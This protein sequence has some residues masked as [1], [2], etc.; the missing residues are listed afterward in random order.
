MPTARRTS[1]WRTGSRKAWRCFWGPVTGGSAPARTFMVG[2]IDLDVET[3]AGSVAVADVDGD[4]RLDLLAGTC[5]GEKCASSLFVLAGKGDGSFDTATPYDAVG[6]G[7]GLVVTADVNGDAAP[8]AV[9]ASCADWRCSSGS[10]AILLRDTASGTGAGAQSDTSRDLRTLASASAITTGTP[11]AAAFNLQVVSDASPDL[12]ICS[13][14]STAPRRAGRRAAEKVWALFYWSHILKRQT[15][16]IVLHGFEV[17][18]PIRNF[19]DYGFTMCSTITG[20][21]P[22]AVREPSASSTSTGTSAIT[23][24]RRSSTTASSTWSTARCRTSSRRTT[25]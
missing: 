19:S 1:S 4:G 12:P 17:T 2:G 14:S 15:A 18:D 8:D 5:F 16:P 11:G 23:P 21:Q 7:A 6:F 22:V 24:C 10:A 13:A 9:V 3:R 25:A 20:H